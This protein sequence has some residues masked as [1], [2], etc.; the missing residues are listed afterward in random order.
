[1]SN[2]DSIVIF[3]IF[4]FDEIIL[5][6]FFFSFSLIFLKQYNVLQYMKCQLGCSTVDCYFSHEELFSTFFICYI[7]IYFFIFFFPFI[8]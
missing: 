3:F 4:F 2:L 6:I 5:F 1:M 7:S 8:Y